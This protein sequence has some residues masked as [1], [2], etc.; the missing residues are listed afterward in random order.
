MSRITEGCGIRRS[1]SASGGGVH[2]GTSEGFS[3]GVG[4]ACVVDNGAERDWTGSILSMCWRIHLAAPDLIP[5]DVQPLSLVC[6]AQE[7]MKDIA[8]RPM[9]IGMIEDWLVLRPDRERRYGV[10]GAWQRYWDAV[11]LG[12]V[13]NPIPQNTPMKLSSTSRLCLSSSKGRASLG[14]LEPNTS[15]QGL[16]RLIFGTSCTATVPRQWRPLQK[17]RSRRRR[18]MKGYQR[19]RSKTKPESTEGGRRVSVLKRQEGAPVLLG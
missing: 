7:R 2:R 11:G 8:D 18:A 1:K 12:I 10:K 14:G 13:K 17:Q 3:R 19:Q 4:T 6:A 9:E 16:T 5:E 15:T